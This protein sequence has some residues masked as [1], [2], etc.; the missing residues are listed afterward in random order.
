MILLDSDVLLIAHRYQH[1]PKFAENAQALQQIQADF[2]HL[3]IREAVNRESSTS[4]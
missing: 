3:G 4:N 1:D 2:I